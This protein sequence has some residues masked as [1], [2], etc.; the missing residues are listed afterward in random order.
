MEQRWFPIVICPGC[1][2]KMTVRLVLPARPNIRRL[3]TIVYHCLQCDLET[4]RH[5]TAPDVKDAA[6]RSGAAHIPKKEEQV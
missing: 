6:N 2:V 5:S 3:E 4:T 1:Q